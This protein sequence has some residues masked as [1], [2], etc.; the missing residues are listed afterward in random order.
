[1]IDA[2]QLRARAKRRHAALLVA[3]R[4]P[5]Y[6]RVLGRFVQAGL[7][8]TTAEVKPYTAAVSVH[9]ALW[10]GEL[11]PR[12]LELLPAAIVKRPGLFEDVHDLPEDLADAVHALRRNQE[13]A[14][15]RGIPG[16]ALLRWLPL[17][18]HRNKL[19]SRLKSFRLQVEDLELLERLSSTLHATQTEVL[20]RSLRRLAATHLVK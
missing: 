9:D 7:L 1:V 13:P 19:P 12:I 11:E 5:R 14:E 3:R 18:G 16:A 20:R 6:R 2:N 4:D 8:T 15:L 10:A 17:L